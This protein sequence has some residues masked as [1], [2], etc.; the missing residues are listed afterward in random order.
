MRSIRDMTRREL[1]AE[2]KARAA[3]FEERFINSEVLASA[4][5][6][7]LWLEEV[8]TLGVLSAMRHKQHAKK[9]QLWQGLQIPRE[10]LTR[11][12]G[13]DE[14]PW[15]WELRFMCE[16]FLRFRK[17]KAVTGSAEHD[18]D[19]IRSEHIGKKVAELLRAGAFG[20][21][22][23][24]SECLIKITNREPQK[25]QKMRLASL[26]NTRV[27]IAFFYLE[28]KGTTKP[29][30][31]EVRSLLKQHGQEISKQNVS[32]VF[33]RLELNAKSSYGRENQSAAGKRRC[34]IIK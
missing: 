16:N 17:P 29:S 34:G 5:N 2:E 22:R 25:A 32:K 23:F 1:I 26:A 6:D 18:R 9:N 28:K 30:Q 15:E 14:H 31:S 13:M 8:S 12:Q 10:F 27:L 33:A 4:L 3:Q 19:V 21:P 24:V 11:V 20:A 7:E